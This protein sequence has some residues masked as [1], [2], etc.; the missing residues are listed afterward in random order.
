MSRVKG[1]NKRKRTIK[2]TKGEKKGTEYR[3]PCYRRRDIKYF[4][5]KWI[6]C[7]PFKVSR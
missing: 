2:K 6:T 1:N 5:L 4:Y 7:R 3:N